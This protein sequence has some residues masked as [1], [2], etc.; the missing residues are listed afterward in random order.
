M[1]SSD[2][3]TRNG[4]PTAQLAKCDCRYDVKV[5]VL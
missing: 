1:G 3:E 5:Q 2:R 4:L